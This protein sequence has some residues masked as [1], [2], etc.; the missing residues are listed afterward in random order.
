MKKIIGF[1]GRKR[2]GKGLLTDVIKSEEKNV[3]VITVANYLKLLCCD[4]LGI[5][6][7]TLNERKDNG[8][9]FEIYPDKRWFDLINTQTK[10]NLDTIKKEISTIKFTS[11]RQMLQ[12]IGT[13]LIRKYNADWHV[14]AMINDINSYS[15]DHVIVIDDIRFP[16]EV[17]AIKDL[18]GD[19]YF[20][21][22][23]NWFYDIS[24]HI[25]ETS[26]KWA[27]F[28]KNHIIINDLSK[29][30]VIDYFR[31]SYNCNF[32]NINVNPIFLCGNEKFYEETYLNSRAFCRENK[33]TK[34]IASEIIK[35]NSNNVLFL[36]KGILSIEIINSIFREHLFSEI[37]YKDI[38]L[39]GI[40]TLVIYNPLINENLKMYF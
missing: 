37:L 14:N 16:N 40:K 3:V 34:S 17:K 6:L 11:I 9:S 22:R 33:F 15:D 31:I 4:I 39:Y 19:V 25:S 13:D 32:N 21:I 12:V 38:P 26:I 2:S 35:Q 1:A 18:G 24:N 8:Y 36:E 23:P 5:D 27:D 28:D 7:N 10:I 29:Q 20:I 30:K